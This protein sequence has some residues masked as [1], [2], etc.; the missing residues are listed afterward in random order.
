MSSTMP[1]KPSSKSFIPAWRVPEPS[2]G[3]S[4]WARRRSSTACRSS[5]GNHSET[6]YRFAERI[7]TTVQTLRLQNR[8]VLAYQREALIAH[9]AGQPAPALV[10]VVV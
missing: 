1:V 9:R 3:E 4:H 7:L 8:H 10:P 6:G 5:A 2:G